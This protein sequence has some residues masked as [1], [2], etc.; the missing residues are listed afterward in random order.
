VHRRKLKAKLVYL[1]KHFLSERWPEQKRVSLA[2]AL[3]L[4]KFPRGAVIFK[5]GDP[6]KTAYF[7]KKGMWYM[8]F[9]LRL[10]VRLKS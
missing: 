5:Q 2:Y 3:K 7:I 10:E 8:L 4:R 1:K 6:A 9:N